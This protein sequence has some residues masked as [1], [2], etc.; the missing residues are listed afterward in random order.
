MF[1]P[2]VESQFRGPKFSEMLK[3]DDSDSDV[4]PSNL[5][6]LMQSRVGLMAQYSIPT[7]SFI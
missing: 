4:E 2:L 7:L 6:Q 5:S 1:K 3:L